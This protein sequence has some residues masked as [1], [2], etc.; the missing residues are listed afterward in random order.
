M[1]IGYRPGIRFELI[2]RILRMHDHFGYRD[3]L[4][5]PVIEGS[6]EEP[7]PDSGAPLK[8]GEFILGYP[9]EFGVTADRPQPGILARNS[10][11]MAYRRLQEHVGKFREF[12]RQDADTPEEQEL[13]AAKLV[14]NAEFAQGNAHRWSREA[15]AILRGDP[16]DV[17]GRERGNSTNAVEV[18][19]ARRRR[20]ARVPVARMTDRRSRPGNRAR[21]AVPRDDSPC[22]DAARSPKRNWNPCLRCRA[23][24]RSWFNIGRW[25]PTRAQQLAQAQDIVAIEG[26]RDWWS[27]IEDTLRSKAAISRESRCGRSAQPAR[28]AARD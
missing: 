9:D 28:L 23:M 22:R 27:Q 11:Y 5:Q 17:R 18:A 21:R 12:L 1:T 16:D 8:A 15:Y 19:G 25:A 24:R 3:R 26:G 6:G 10:S 20:R 13:I 2:R 4:S 14:P 7:T